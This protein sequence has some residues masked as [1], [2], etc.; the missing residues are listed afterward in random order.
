MNISGLTINIPIKAE[1]DAILVRDNGAIDATAISI[2]GWVIRRSNDPDSYERG[3]SG[4]QDNTHVVVQN[5]TLDQL[6]GNS[7][8]MRLQYCTRLVDQNEITQAG[9]S[10][11]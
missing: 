1:P 2:H 3:M 5:N 7:F 9:G 6:Y 11:V 10:F 4:S 8:A